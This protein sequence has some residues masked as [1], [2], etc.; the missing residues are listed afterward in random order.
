MAVTVAPAVSDPE[1]P[2]VRPLA[3]VRDHAG[4]EGRGVEIPLTDDRGRPQAP[5]RVIFAP[6]TSEIL[7]WSEGGADP[8][9]VHTYLAW[10]HVRASG[11]RP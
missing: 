8:G 2:G 4:R 5:V 1:R 9:E 10:G 3:S 7:E 6:H 11:D